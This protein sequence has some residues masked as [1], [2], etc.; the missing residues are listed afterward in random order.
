MEN[1]GAQLRVRTYPSYLPT[2]AVEM[3]K[4]KSRWRGLYGCHWPSR[5]GEKKKRI[6][7]LGYV[8]VMKFFQN[9]FVIVTWH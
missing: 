1:M 9:V 7:V 5:R 4:R 2:A 6:Q 3:G 8:L